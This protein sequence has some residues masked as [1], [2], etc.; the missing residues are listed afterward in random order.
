MLL[1]LASLLIHSNTNESTNGSGRIIYSVG[2]GGDWNSTTTW[3]G[4]IIPMSRDKAVLVE[5]TQV[6]V[7]H[8]VWIYQIQLNHSATLYLGN[9]DRDV[10][11]TFDDMSGAGLLLIKGSHKH[12]NLVCNGSKE[13]PVNISCGPNNY[14]RLYN[15]TGGG[16]PPSLDIH[17]TNTTWWRYR[18]DSSMDVKSE[19][20][21]DNCTLI[22]AY[23]KTISQTAEDH[24]QNEVPFFKNCV[25]TVSD[26]VEFPY[27]TRIY[28]SGIFEHCVID[29]PDYVLAESADEIMIFYKCIFPSINPI[30]YPISRLYGKYYPYD[31]VGGNGMIFYD[32]KNTDANSDGDY[33]CFGGGGQP[34][35][36]LCTGLY[37]SK[38]PIKYLPCDADRILVTGGHNLYGFETY[39]D[40]DYTFYKITTNGGC[41]GAWSCEPHIFFGNASQKLNF[42]FKDLEGGG[43]FTTTHLNNI[44]QFVN[45]SNCNFSKITNTNYTIFDL[46]NA[47]DLKVRDVTIDGIGEVKI[48]QPDKGSDGKVLYGSRITLED[49]K[50]DNGVYGLIFGYNIRNDTILLLSNITINNSQKYGLCINT[51]SRKITIENISIKHSGIADIRLS[52]NSVLELRNSTFSTID[53]NNTNWTVFSL[54]NNRTDINIT[55]LSKTPISNK[56][57]FV[58]NYTGQ[59]NILKPVGWDNWSV[60]DETDGIDI[61][62]ESKLL[63]GYIQFNST[64]GKIYTIQKV[65]G[66]TN[67]SQQTNPYLNNE[68]FVILEPPSL[69]SFRRN[70]FL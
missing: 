24:I 17:A 50:M 15:I 13:N 25:I 63:D 33:V 31:I 65:D 16:V 3:V 1:V 52:N 48:G 6:N 39:F 57:T 22:C 60:Y 68:L 58:S 66:K 53:K 11:L 51:E 30:S 7:T 12:L 61:T 18:W 40:I 56:I 41:N 28:S 34:M 54:F 4:G 20:R 47:L 70:F 44:G 35:N 36:S 49:I 67:Q 69:H 37:W 46:E 14:W 21:F 27:T 59:H 32:Y 26:D 42:I 38:I 23:G 62:K 2:S 9:C 43:I 29:I 55:W 19:I 8:D 45:I 10:N 5:N 64:D